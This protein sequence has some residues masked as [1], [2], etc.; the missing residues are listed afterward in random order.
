MSDAEHQR[1]HTSKTLVNFG[2]LTM[3]LDHVIAAIQARDETASLLAARVAAL[4]SRRTM[5]FENAY[6]PGRRYRAGDCVQ[7]AGGLFVALAATSE[8]PG[9][10]AQWRRIGDAR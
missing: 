7:R 8:Q 5:S 4:E 1:L 2:A 6:D 10:S 9:S 3:A